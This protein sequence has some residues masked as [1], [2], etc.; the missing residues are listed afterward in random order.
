MPPAKHNNAGKWRSVE[1]PRVAKVQRALPK[2]AFIAMVTPSDWGRTAIH[3]GIA[4][5]ILIGLVISSG[6]WV[7]IAVFAWMVTLR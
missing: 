3:M 6:L 1:Q 2:P 7:G 5:G 4:R